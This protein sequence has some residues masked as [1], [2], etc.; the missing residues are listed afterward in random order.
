VQPIIAK[1]ILPWFGGTAGVWTVCMLFFQV[2]LL[3]GYLYAYWSVRGLGPRAQGVLHIVLLAASLLLLPMTP[4]ETWKPSGAE[5]P[6]LR[7]LGLLAAS[8]GLPYFLLSTTGPLVQAWY[9]RTNCNGIPYRLFALSNL[10]SMLALLSYP[11]LVEPWLATRLQTQWWSVLYGVFVAV[12]CAAAVRGCFHGA[13]ASPSGEAAAEEAAPPRWDLQLLWVA[14]ATCPSALMLAVTHHLSKNVAPIPFLWILPLGIYLLSFILCFEGRRWYNRDWYLK[15]LLAAFF[16]F[17]YGLSKYGETASLAV[18]VSIFAAGLFIFCMVCHGELAGLKPHPRYLTSFYL[19]CSLGG[20][21]GG[22]FVGLVAPYLFASA[23]EI[24]IILAASTFLPVLVLWRYPSGPSEPVRKPQGLWAVALLGAV[25]LAYLSFQIYASAGNAQLVVRN[26]FGVLKVIDSEGAGER[27]ATRSMT[28]GVINH[29]EQFLHPD[30]RRHPTTYFGPPSGI[31][32]TMTHHGRQAPQRV[33]V[34][35]LGAGVLATYGRP[36]DYYRFYEINAHVIDVA[37]SHFTFLKDCRATVDVVLADGRLALEREPDQQFDILAV[38][39]FSGDAIPAHLL[40][41]EIFGSYFRHLK[42]DGVLALHVSSTYLDLGPV[43]ELAAR[44]L[45]R[46]ARI[47][48]SEG[49]DAQRLFGA[50]WIL[51]PNHRAFFQLP[52]ISRVARRLETRPGLRMWTDDYSN[53]LRIIR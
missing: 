48:D 8:I 21:L 29:G 27:D 51:V 36:G 47:V 4:A 24:R 43:V 14:L 18:V 40:T 52:A 33:G 17:S 7:I 2:M 31:G 5:E 32:L 22:A 1:V 45:G 23:Y 6:T 20:A 39:A 25:L 53:L 13:T 10:G 19:M 16:G 30:R 28:H 50:F 15:L 9:A 35:G 42:P 11:A 38:D 44:D 46:E 37:R 34:I 3:A 26:F 12:G 41:R 49:D